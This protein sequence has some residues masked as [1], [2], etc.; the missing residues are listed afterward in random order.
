MPRGFSRVC[1]AF[2]AL[3]LAGC[4]QN[5]GWYVVSPAT[6]S[7]RTNL[8]F[9]VDGLGYTIALSATAIAISI[10]VGLMIA[11]PGLARARPARIFNRVYV[12]GFRAIPILVLL[13]WVY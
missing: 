8:G 12:E 10:V 5:W 4:G 3:G 9:L 13:L 11:L 2:L 6:E 7:G 1:V